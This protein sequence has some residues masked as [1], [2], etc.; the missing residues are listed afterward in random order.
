ML[1]Y[2]DDEIPNDL[3]VWVEY[4]HPD[5][6]EPVMAAA[7]E[8][9]DGKV[10]EYV[11]EHRMLHKDGSVRWMLT[12]GRTIR[13]ASGQPIRM[14]G[15][16]AD[17]TERKLA[18]DE[19]LRLEERLRHA[20]KMEAL[21]TLAGGIAHD[22]N[23]LLLAI[24]GFSELVREDVPSG[25]VAHENVEQ[26]LRAAGR[27][28]GVV[29]RILTFAR[30]TEAELKPLKLHSPVREA[31]ELL[32]TVLPPKIELQEAVADN[33]GVVYAD[34]SQ[35]HQLVVNLATNAADAIGEDGGTVRITLEPADV[36]EELATEIGTLS[37]ARYVELTVR[38]TGCGMEGSTVKAA[39][40]PFF[41]TKGVGAGTGLGLSVVHGIVTNHGGALRVV[42]E[43]GRGS[44]FHVYLPAVDRARPEVRVV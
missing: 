42:S 24:T 30:Q 27:A 39:F 32:R 13:D 10:A 16:D 21:G 4:V 35:I 2:R 15:T 5:D 37:P 43:P 22:F 25:S 11:Y 7:Q 34:G 26:V 6:R 40:D 1:G 18:E 14:V 38:D 8:C 23:N 31:V 3:E 19:H 17:I 29:E 9:L 12:R 33:A 44:S 41:T 28:K 36:D 20:Q